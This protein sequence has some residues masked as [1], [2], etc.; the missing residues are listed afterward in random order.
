MNGIHIEQVFIS[1]VLLGFIYEED[2]DELKS[3]RFQTFTLCL[4]IIGIKFTVW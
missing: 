1:G 3:V 2:Y 4:F